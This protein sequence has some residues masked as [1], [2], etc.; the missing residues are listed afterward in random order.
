MS[1]G[2]EIVTRDD[3]RPALEDNYTGEGAKEVRVLL[4]PQL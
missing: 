2:V 4:H 3:Y 1:C